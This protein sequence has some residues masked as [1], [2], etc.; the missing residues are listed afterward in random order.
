MDRIWKWIGW[1]PAWGTLAGFALVILGFA[2]SAIDWGFITLAALGTFGPGILRE[3]G[4]LND[5]DEFQRRVSRKAGYHAY[6]VTGLLAF[7]LIAYYRSAENVLEKADVLLELFLVI[8]WFTWF[9]S[10][11]LD[12]WGPAR[13]V[14][15][16]LVAFGIFWAIFNILG[17]LMS[18][19]AMFMQTL[20][21]VP[22]FLLAWTAKRWP[23]L[24]GGLLVLAACF[25]F[26]TFDMYKI[27]G[28]DPLARGRGHIIVLFFGPLFASGILLIRHGG[29]ESDNSDT[30]IAEEH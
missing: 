8:L 4:L 27:I 14:T 25:F 9:F 1:Q 5:Q 6:L 20:L 16:I 7:F 15:R 13:T 11:L 17:N 3:M 2:L 12:Y 28:P 23:R 10:S 29:R 26:F 22:F 30:L 18:P 24:A 19:V 21:A